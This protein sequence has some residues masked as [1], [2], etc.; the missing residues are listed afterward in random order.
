MSTTPD[1]RI[2]GL[3]WQD[4]LPP[5][6]LDFKLRAVNQ[7]M[8][9][10]YGA[11]FAPHGITPFQWLVLACLWQ[12]DGLRVSEVTQRL[13]QVGGTMTGIVQGMEKVG[14][15]SRETLPQDR[16]VARLWLTEKGAGLKETLLPISQQVNKDIYKCLEEPERQE[17]SLL[18]DKLLQHLTT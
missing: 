1:K 9:R 4:V 7:L 12:E 3:Q 6:S 17:L 14:L 11:A 2:L 15:I 13:N 16:R 8:L 5:T 10:R 18:L